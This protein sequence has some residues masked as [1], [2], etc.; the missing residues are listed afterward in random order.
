MNITATH[1]YGPWEKSALVVVPSAAAFG[2]RGCSTQLTGN[3]IDGVQ[4]TDPKARMQGSRTW[5]PPIT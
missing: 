3:G 1:T 2:M 5:S 4:T